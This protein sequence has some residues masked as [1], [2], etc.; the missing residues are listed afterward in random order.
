MDDIKIETRPAGFA[1]ETE[2]KVPL[3]KIAKFLGGAFSDL[4]TQAKASGVAVE[5]MPY[6]RYLNVDWDDEMSAG[7]LKRVWRLLTQKMHMR[8]GMATAA[9]GNS[10][11][12]IEAVEIP[13]R[14]YVTTLHKGPYHQV[15]K[16]Y[17]RIY[18]WAQEN[19]VKLQNWSVENYIND[20]TT[21][22][23]ADIETLVLV[24]V[25]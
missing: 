9:L 15:G 3:M 2:S 20:P 24:P 8:A 5:G 22:D 17:K 14:K 23:K 13:S 11:G 16:T 18:L 10:N 4:Q 21:V 25:K 6:C 19:D 1:L 7:A 12:A